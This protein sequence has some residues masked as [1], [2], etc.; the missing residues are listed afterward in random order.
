M[1]T[2]AWVTLLLAYSKGIGSNMPLG[3]VA[4]GDSQQLWEDSRS[5]EGRLIFPT[6][7]SRYA[8]F[9]TKISSLKES[10]QSIAE[11]GA[12]KKRESLAAKV[13]DYIRTIEGVLDRSKAMVFKWKKI[14]ASTFAQEQIEGCKVNIKTPALLKY[15]EHIKKDM[16]TVI[17]AAPLDANDDVTKPS[18]FAITLDLFL[19]MLEG[20]LKNYE[21]ELKNL[22]AAIEALSNGEFPSQLLESITEAENCLS[23]SQPELI[24]VKGCVGTNK[25]YSCDL[26]ITVLIEIQEGFEA[27]PLPFFE[28]TNSGSYVQLSIP[29]ALVD[30]T[31]SQI[32]NK[33]NCRMEKVGRVCQKDAWVPY[34]CF[35][36]WKKGDKEEVLNNCQFERKS[37]PSFP[38]IRDTEMGL[39]VAKRSTTAITVDWKKTDN[40]ET[41]KI[42]VILPTIFTGNGK[43]VINNDWEHIKRNVKLTN[44]NTEASTVEALIPQFNLS[45]LDIPESLDSQDALFD[46]DGDVYNIIQLGIACL[47]LLISLISVPCCLHYCLNFTRRYRENRATNDLILHSLS[48][49]PHRSR[50]RQQVS[51]PSTER[52]KQIFQELL[53][54]DIPKKLPKHVGN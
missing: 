39:L 30:I 46:W 10:L 27:I 40:S 26:R 25:G 42:P 2:F 38:L 36:A 53:D 21:N 18:A 14:Q 5:N 28:E 31:L 35:V 52:D 43:L 19:H 49:R 33:D 54:K 13:M 15:V 37:D 8:E 29:N 16:A 20:T 34:P 48:P 23:L 9:D 50:R 45:W 47:S 12:I 3:L 1:R 32:L 4:L 22:L 51:N 7:P 6:F 41:I 24:E 11:I 44:S 17:S